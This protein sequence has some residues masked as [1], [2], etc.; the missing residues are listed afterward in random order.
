MTTDIVLRYVMD[1]KEEIAALYPLAL[2][3][4]NDQIEVGLTD[5]SKKD[6]NTYI[7]FLSLVALNVGVALDIEEKEMEELLEDELILSYLYNKI[8]KPYRG[9]VSKTQCQIKES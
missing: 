1:N 6:F 8:V 7:N 2:D 5:N 9:E 3:M 4:T